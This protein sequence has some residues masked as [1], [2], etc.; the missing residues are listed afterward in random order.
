MAGYTVAITADRRSDEQAELLRRR[1]AAVLHGPTI[2]TLPLD[3]TSRMRHATT[4]VIAHPPD[5][6]ALTTAIG[7]RSWLG[8]AESLGLGDALYQALDQA[9]VLA[10]GPKTA[11]AAAGL[12]VE[13]HEVTTQA[14]HEE[15]LDRVAKLIASHPSDRRLRVAVQLDGA[16]Q[17]ATEQL[18]ALGVDVVAL[19]VYRWVL[20]DDLT[21][22]ERVIT[23]VAEHAVDAVT[24]TCAHAVTNFVELATRAGLLDQVRTGFSRGVLACAVGPV[25]AARLRASAVATEPIEP[26]RPRLGSMVQALTRALS[27]RRTLLRVGNH[28]V[29][30]QGRLVYVSPTR[31]VLLTDRERKV[32]AVLVRRPGAVVS[33]RELLGQVWSHDTDPH[34]VEV[35]VGRLRR[36]LGEAGIGVETVMRRGYRL[37]V[38]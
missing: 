1:G 6:V 27:T 4:Q 10:R 25:T 33:K 35:T 7:V 38:I 2:K 20:P 15:L 32:F 30:I 13:V 17:P 11:G 19:P 22:A 12:G 29:M 18:R 28:E 36:R 31:S 23:A 16:G 24:F 26:V 37:A 3:E 5:V 21:P 8:A 9:L 14:T 34:V